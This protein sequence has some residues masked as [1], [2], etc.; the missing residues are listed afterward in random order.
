MRYGAAIIL[1][2]LFNIGPSI[3]SWIIYY[4]LNIAPNNYDVNKINVGDVSKREIRIKAVNN[5]KKNIVELHKTEKCLNIKKAWE[6]GPSAKF[7]AGRIAT[8]DAF[9]VS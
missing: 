3:G 7:H 9:L 1:R 2:M 6:G 5:G 8:P 4:G